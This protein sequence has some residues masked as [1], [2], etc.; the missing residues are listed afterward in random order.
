[1]KQ[2]FAEFEMGMQQEGVNVALQ[3]SQ[4]K[5]KIVLLPVPTCE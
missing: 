4:E 3:E 1:M 5:K 2:D